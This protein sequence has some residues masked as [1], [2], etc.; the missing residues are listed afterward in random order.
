[1]R[2]EQSTQ[3]IFKLCLLAMGFTILIFVLFQHIGFF[4]SINDLLLDQFILLSDN[5]QANENLLVIEIDD[6]SVTKLGKPVPRS[7]YVKLIQKLFSLGVK[8]IVFDLLF[9]D[10]SDSNIDSQLAST[11]ETTQH[12]IHCFMFS[13]E[14]PDSNLFR[15]R[16]YEKYA[17]QVENQAKLNVLTAQNGTFPHRKFIHE[18]NQAGFI[19]TEWDYDGRS[20]RVPL[21]YEFDHRIYP[22]LGLV[23]L[24]DYLGVAEKTVMIENSFWGR[25]AMVKTPDEVIKIPINSKGQVLLNFYGTLDVFKP[26][27]LHE[28]INLLDAF[29]PTDRSQLPIPLFKDKIALIGNTET[30]KDK[31]ETP[32]SAEFPGVGFHSTLLSNIL[33]DDFITEAS[34]KINAVTSTILCLLLLGVFILYYLKLLKSIW[35]FCIIAV[36]LFMLHNLIAHFL[37]F[38]DYHIWLKLI[39]INSTYLLLFFFLLFY[40]KVIRLKELNTKIVQIENDIFIKKTDLEKLDQKINSQTEQYKLI[41]FFANEL[42][43]VFNNSTM[44]QPE[45]LEKFYPQF[46]ERQEII[47]AKLTSEIEQLKIEKEKIGKEK[48]KL[49]HEKNIYQNILNGNRSREP[50]FIPE[51]SKTDKAMIAQQIMTGWQ[52]FQTQRKRGKLQSNSVSGIIALTT[53]LNEKG[54]KI[55]TPMGEI[56]DKINKISHFDSTVLITGEVGT[57]KELVANAIHQQSKRSTHRLVTINCAAIPENLLESEL[58]GHVKGAFTDAKF[59]HKGAFEYADGGTIFL[60]EIGELKLDMQAKLL[61]VLQNNEIQKVGSNQ[62]IKVDVRIVAATNKNLKKCIEN[63]QFRSDLFSRLNVVDLYIPPLRQR[64][65]DIPFLIQQFL[66]DFNRNY[67]KEKSFSN[68]AVI[69]AMC[70]QWP[71]NIRML[72]HLVEKVCV[73][74]SDDEIPLAALP[75]EIQ[76]AYR[77]IFESAEVPWW[78]HIEEIVHHELRRLLD[79]CQIAIKDDSIDEFLKS[80][81]LQADHKPLANCYEYFK[82]FINGIASIF[83]IDKR[84][85]LVRKTIVEM[86]E[87]LFHWCR[88]EKV[89]KLGDMYDMIE[90][91]LGRSRRQIDNWRKENSE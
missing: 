43:S 91:M 23:A 7:H 61:R 41:Q 47:K 11:T 76:L 40:E 22:N 63:N 53:I 45:H 62:T 87:Q 29:Q 60:D 71:D 15:D 83:P 2:F 49:E 18:F 36:S 33:Q 79:V 82:A 4:H 70:Y 13:D 31:H 54:E 16:R 90:K 28:I 20:R 30:G 46:F 74:T 51:Q 86:Q 85:T 9:I 14:K 27:S 38:G 44:D 8:T 35:T 56:I 57:G 34:W 77:H 32:F 5:R 39:Q 66:N 3:Q 73:L 78:S 50:G 88:Q 84:E 58:F 72:Q 80:Q 42:K 55:M 65:Y 67:N 24:F 21:F 12:I 75:E 37:L 69:A 64:K 48:E 6:E 1:M 19:T 68:E 25:T 52:Y 59:D 26:V 89:G 81:H 17:I 10:E